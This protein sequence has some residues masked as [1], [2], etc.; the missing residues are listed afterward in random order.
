MPQ[1]LHKTFKLKQKLLLKQ[2]HSSTELRFLEK[3]QALDGPPDN[4]NFP[5]VLTSVWLCTLHIH[6]HKRK[7][8]N[9]ILS[10][11]KKKKGNVP[12][13]A[14]SSG[15]LNDIYSIY[16]Y[17]YINNNKTQLSAYKNM[18]SVSSYNSNLMMKNPCILRQVRT[19]HL[20]YQC[21]C[22][23]RVQLGITCIYQQLQR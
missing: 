8:A 17:I 11:K 23:A 6:L 3:K 5:P 22:T 2:F 21:Q 10:E 15:K 18:S 9:P 13:N 7:K 19:V 16:I 4:L 12:N 1:L 20:T 14:F